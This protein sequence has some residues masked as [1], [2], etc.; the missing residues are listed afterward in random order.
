MHDLP[1]C[2]FC[3][4]VIQ[5]VCVRVVSSVGRATSLTRLSAVA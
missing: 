4:S 2:F 1:L 5:C 3:R